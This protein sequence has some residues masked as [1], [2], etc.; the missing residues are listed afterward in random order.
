MDRLEKYQKIAENAVSDVAAKLAQQTD[1][2][3]LLLIDREHGQ[4][5]V[6]SDGWEDTTRCYGPV[7]HIE[8][9]ADG[10]VWLRYDGTDLEIGASL[11]EN[12]VLPQD[13][14]L[15]FYSPNMRKFATTKA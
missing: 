8:V 6:L 1:I 5:I 13:I 3:A 9:K 14:V 15:A 10:M 11:I 4:Y 7:V 12:G 2:E